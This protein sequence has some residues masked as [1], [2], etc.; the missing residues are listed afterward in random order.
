MRYQVSKTND[1][2][3]ITTSSK[4]SFIIQHSSFSIQNYLTIATQNGTVKIQTI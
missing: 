3:Q 4:S 1:H 2:I